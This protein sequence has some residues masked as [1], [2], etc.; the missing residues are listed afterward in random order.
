MATFPAL[1]PSARTF[2]P[3]EYPNTG[4]R[5][6]NGTE[7]RVRHSNVMLESTLRLAF[8]EITETQML[9]I[10]SHYQSQ[11]GGFDSFALSSEVWSGL[12][13]ISDFELTGYRWRYAEAPTVV[14]AYS[15]R[16]TVELSLVTVPPEGATVNGFGR[17]VVLSIAG[18]TVTVSDGFNLTVNVSFAPGLGDAPVGAD[19]LTEQID[20]SIAGGDVQIIPA[21]L[22]ETI[23]VTFAAGA[24]AAS[25]G[26]NEIV[27][28]SIVGGTASSSATDPDFANVGLLLHM[29]GA[30]GSTTFTDSSSNNH[31]MTVSGSA[32]ISTAQSKFGGASGIF[33]GS[34]NFLRTPSSSTLAF[35]TGGFT[36]ECWAYFTSLTGTQVLVSYGTT[37]VVLGKNITTHTM[38]GTISNTS[39]TGTTAVALNTWYHFALCRSGTT[40]RLFVNGVEEGTAITG[41]TTNFTT[42]QC[43]IARRTDST[44]YFLGHL[45]DLRIT[46]AGRYSANFTPPTEAF[47]DS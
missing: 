9:S 13:S 31:S 21:G 40:V 6:W 22:A 12:S 47:P 45:D 43:E 46:K 25:N 38:F 41:S 28:V 8:N 36:V 34:G 20:L 19:G 27:T 35:G 32:Q 3:G 16:H 39:I 15:G 42:N 44:R 37:T 14:D 1:A 26:L 17:I 11:R 2:T 29:D 23:D 5:A 24:V 4:F 33:T 10:L 30:N 7:E 18:G